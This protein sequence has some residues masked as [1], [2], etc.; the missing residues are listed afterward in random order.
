MALSLEEKWILVAIFAVIGIAAVYFEVRYMRSKSREIREVD[1]KGDEAHNAIL[2]T[3]SVINAM[4]TRGMD[5]GA[6]ERLILSARQALQRKQYDHCM[7]L[8]EQARHE[9]TNPSTSASASDEDAG[10]SDLEEVAKSILRS[11]SGPSSADL[12]TGSKLS[13]DRD[14]NYL[15]AKFEINTAKIDLKEAVDR[16]S[17]TSD[18]QGLLTDAEGAFVAGNYTKALSLAL[19][20]RKA[21][22]SEVERETIPLKRVDGEESET[23]PMPDESSGHPA[24]RCKEC[25]SLLDSGDTFCGVCGA[26][27][28]VERICENCGAKSRSDD[29]FCR[30]CGASLI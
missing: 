7:R 3:R 20:S 5:T 21:I 16:G 2:T 17:D 13:V 6:S 24:Q 30:K 26:K 19:R 28:L 27:V 23:E 25:S 22:S 12:Y 4:Q 9:L 18:A 14:G 15:S 10:G 11:D 8:C 1:Q 29:K